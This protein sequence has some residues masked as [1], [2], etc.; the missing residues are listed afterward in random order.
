MMMM[1][2]TKTIDICYEM[3]D[4]IVAASESSNLAT[5]AAAAAAAP[6]C[7]CCSWLESNEVS[8]AL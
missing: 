3:H 2:V 1:V 4:T 7:C 8:L 6:L 5:T